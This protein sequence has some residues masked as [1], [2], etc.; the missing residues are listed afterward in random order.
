MKVKSFFGI[1]FLLFYCSIACFGFPFN[2][3]VIP[4]AKNGVIDLRN[5]TDFTERTELNGQWLF[6]WHQLLDPSARPAVKGIAVN[7]PVPW[8]EQKINGQKLPAYGYA[9]YT[10]TLLLPK[11][12]PQLRISTPDVYSAYRL[13]LDG[14]K[15]AENGTVATNANDFVP[16]WGY[17]A[18]DVPAGADSIHLTLQIAN[19]AHSKG[20]IS[21]ALVIQQKDIMIL[22][23]RRGEAVDLLLTGC[24]FMGGL[25]FLGLYLFGSR[26][27]AILLFSLY[28]IVYCYRI[29]G[30]D[31]YV[32]HTILPDASWYLMVRLEYIT[33]FSGIGLFGLYTRY[34]CPDDV[35]LKIIGVICSVC[36][37]F[38]LVSM[39]V[40]PYY[41]SQLINP[42]LVIT[43][44]CLVYIPYVYTVAYRKQ[45]PGSVYA[46]ASSLA[47]MGVFAISLFHYWGFIPQLQFLSFLGYVSFFFLQSL[48][49]SHRV[50]FVL[51]KAREQAEQG[52]IAKSEFLSTMSHE[53]R[54]PLNSVI[55]MSHLLLK[56]NPRKDQLEHLDVMIFSANNLLGIV[57]DILDYNKIE[58][59]MITFEHI[60]TDITSIARNV[61]SSLRS[62]A[63]DKGIVIKLSIDPDINQRVL[64]DPI[65]VSQ[66][67]TNLVHNAIKFTQQGTVDV[68]LQLLQQSEK[69]LT[70]CF[71]VRDTGIGIS[72]SK[73]QLIF[74]RFTQADSSTSRGF[75]GTGLGLSISKRILELQNS[76]LHL[77]SEEGK[78]ST[79]YFEQTF[80]KSSNAPGSANQLLN[81]IHPEKPFTGVNILLVEDNPINVMVAQTFL[82]RWGASIDVAVNGLEAIEKLDI[83]KH[84]LI[85]MDLH[86]PVM[87]GYEASRNIRSKGI[88]LPIIAL[89]AN[90]PKEIEQQVKQTG[91]NDIVVKP[92]LPD[93]LYR[94]VL[95]HISKN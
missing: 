64:T 61:V 13:F 71:K 85:L 28:S 84:Q 78:G 51:T 81:T 10:L 67:M 5:Q 90:L 57:N 18:F 19:F 44:Y 23:R 93:E 24:L 68:D 52:L 60:D 41:F 45:R 76:S 46:L 53:I 47:L 1:V 4:I 27:K 25:F 42:F 77:T 14:E 37:L 59:G 12:G 66:V 91:I 69:Q 83:N 86:M 55:G 31:N 26:D 11:G 32:I 2:N 36:G 8:T 7:F 87:D 80:D 29:I 70:L 20:G 88:T 92:F 17:R 95:H 79:F 33:L 62:S 43:V 30:T 40:P 6:Y 89:T 50:S 74:E 73:Q 63:E 58:A 34:L 38:A 21:R 48:V 56:N 16:Y 39:V 94:K 22:G 9:T 82:Q 75:G 35:N 3:K 15:I 65:R 72:K 54:T 49:L